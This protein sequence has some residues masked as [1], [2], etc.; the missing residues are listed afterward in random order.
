MQG[1]PGRLQ[2]VWNSGVFQNQEEQVLLGWCLQLTLPLWK[3]EVKKYTE[4]ILRD[5]WSLPNGECGL[6]EVSVTMWACLII[7]P[8]YLPAKDME[9]PS[10]GDASGI[11]LAERILGL[12]IGKEK[13][14]VSREWVFRV[15]CVK[16]SN[17]LLTSF[18][19]LSHS[20]PLPSYTVQ[21]SQV[22]A[23]VW[24][25]SSLQWHCWLLN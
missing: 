2:P 24:S 16:K 20:L 7:S 23:R 18:L 10:L 8:M 6:L 4:I 17:E 1:T 21:L 5:V 14:G 9:S 25:I 22:P 11:C 3:Q 12:N 19:A 15:M 13:T